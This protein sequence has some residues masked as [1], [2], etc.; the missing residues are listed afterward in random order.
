MD[1][2]HTVDFKIDAL[3]PNTIPMVRL[4]KYLER[5]AILM[6]SEDNVHFKQIRKG[7]AIPE[8]FIDPPAIAA[9]IT[10]LSQVAAGIGAP[11]ALKAKDQINQLL[12]EDLSSAT[13]RFRGGAKI[14]YFPGCKTPLAEEAFVLEEGQLIG[15]LIRLGGKDETV[16]VTLQDYDKTTYNCT[17]TRENIKKLAQFIYGEPICV[18]G[19][20]KWRRT[21]FGKWELVEFKIQSWELLETT[22]LEQVVEAIRRIPNNGWDAFTDPQAELRKLREG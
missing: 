2:N 13:L 6:G 15:T 9:V 10:R 5:L 4:A 21:V 12:R 19:K 20:G 14:L 1:L 22:S 17:A 11:D 3:S 8:M 7:S 18:K 16:P